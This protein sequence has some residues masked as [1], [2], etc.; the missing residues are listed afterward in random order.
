MK[1]I[2][3]FTAIALFGITAYGQI[4]PNQKEDK[5]RNKDKEQSIPEVEKDDSETK[6]KITPEEKAARRAEKRASKAIRK[7]DKKADRED[8]GIINESNFG[9]NNHGS[10]VSEVAKGTTLEGKEKG[11]AV[12]AAARAKSRNKEKMNNNSTDHKPAKINKT[13]KAGKG[14]K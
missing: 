2:I 5:I 6:V 9:K 14:K 3:I 4:S 12:N 1:K 13:H 7:A 11:E 10:T 8:D